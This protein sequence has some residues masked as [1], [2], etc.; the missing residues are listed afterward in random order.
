MSAV[1]V[2]HYLLTHNSNL[3]AVVP[4]TKIFSGAI[5]LNTVLPAIAVNEISVTERRT[6]GMN[7]S[8]I[9]TT[10]RIQVSVT[11][12]SYAEQKS[13]LELVRKA[14]PNT[15]GIVNGV[16]V[17]SI[18]PE[19]AGPDLRDDDAGVYLQTRDFIVKF[20]ATA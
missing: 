15:T 6:V 5:P 9:L 19:L 1:K 8:N 4:A 3:L 20:N 16:T 12:K 13:I 10:A 17:D 11:A 2:I 18:L 7:T 14:C